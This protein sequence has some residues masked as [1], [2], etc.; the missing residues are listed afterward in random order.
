MTQYDRKWMQQQKQTGCGLYFENFVENFHSQIATYSDQCF[1][2][3]FS[4][5]I[6]W[7][8]CF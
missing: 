1:I 3:F 7:H 8:M 5:G 2:Y 4:F 6:E